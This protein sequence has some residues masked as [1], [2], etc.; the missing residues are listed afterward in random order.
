MLINQEVLVS[1]QALSFFLV[2]VMFMPPQM[3]RFKIFNNAN[4]LLAMIT[5]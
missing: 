3:I 5:A 4:Y 2:N 1:S